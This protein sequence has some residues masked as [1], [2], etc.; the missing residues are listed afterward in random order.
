MCLQLSTFL[1]ECIGIDT[2]IYS[3]SGLGLATVK[4]LIN[5]N[6]YVSILDLSPP[7]ASVFPDTS[8]G[9]RFIFIK[10]DIANV[11]QV[12]EAVNRTV[13]WTKDTGAVLGGVINCAGLGR[14]ELVSIFFLAPKNES[15]EAE[16]H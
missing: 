3:S 5:A 11:D 2:A 10:T 15:I 16:N 12:Q 8:K 7:P 4:D 13:S 9:E 14:N 6:A 1:I